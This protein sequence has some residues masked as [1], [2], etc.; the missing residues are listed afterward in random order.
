VKELNPCWCQQRLTNPLNK[1]SSN[2]AII[3]LKT[4]KEKDSES[5]KAKKAKIQK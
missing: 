2:E 5:G 1:L 4:R 3:F